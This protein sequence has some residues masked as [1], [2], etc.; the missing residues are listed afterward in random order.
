VA[1]C[2][3][4]GSRSRAILFRIARSF[5]DHARTKFFVS[6]FAYERMVHRMQRAVGKP[7]VRPMVEVLLPAKAKGGKA[8]RLSPVPPWH[9]DF[10]RL[11]N[12]EGAAGARAFTM[13]SLA[14]T[15]MLTDGVPTLFPDLAS[16]R[17]QSRGVVP[18]AAEEVADYA[19]GTGGIFRGR[20]ARSATA[21]RRCSPGGRRLA[22]LRQ[23]RHQLLRTWS[24]RGSLA[25][26][27]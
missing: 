1:C 19:K 10:K 17:T 14:V 21:C 13:P 2:S 5:Q 27:T 20:A 9:G 24:G 23:P 18:K 4:N 8:A 12:N 7:G 22:G 11:R 16:K 3:W 6:F 26:L 15:V 25:P